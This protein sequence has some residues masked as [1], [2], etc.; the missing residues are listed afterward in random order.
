LSQGK[1]VTGSILVAVLMVPFFAVFDFVTD[2]Q[3]VASR[4]MRKS[5]LS[6]IRLTIAVSGA[7]PKTPDMQTERHPGV[8][9]TAL[10]RPPHGVFN[11]GVNSTHVS[12]TAMAHR[13][14]GIVEICSSER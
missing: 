5:A 8:H 4:A 2:E 3:P 14:P 1:P 10:V 9:S 12:P 11:L 6:F 7:G 13:R